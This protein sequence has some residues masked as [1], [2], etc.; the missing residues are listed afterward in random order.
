VQ[1]AQSRYVVH[2]ISGLWNLTAAG[3]AHLAAG[4]PL[5]CHSRPTVSI[6]DWIGLIGALVL[7]IYLTVAL[8]K[9]EY[10]E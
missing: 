3:R 4:T 8:L 10:F 2:G 1:S 9:P 6:F 7:G 5:H